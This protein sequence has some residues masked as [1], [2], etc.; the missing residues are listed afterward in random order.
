MKPEATQ[1]GLG[2]TGF[3][4]TSSRDLLV[5]AEPALSPYCMHPFSDG[6]IQLRMPNFMGKT[7]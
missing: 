2:T 4:A 6:V 5:P 3:P 1:Q 7:V